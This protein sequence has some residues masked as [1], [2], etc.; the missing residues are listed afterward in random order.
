MT[1]LMHQYKPIFECV[2]ACAKIFLNR[3]NV[4]KKKSI[5]IIKETDQE[6]GG[7]EMCM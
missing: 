4:F 3:S 1:Q 6:L 2:Q 7:F 5:I